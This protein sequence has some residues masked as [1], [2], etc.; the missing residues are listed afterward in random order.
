[1]LSLFYYLFLTSI[2][3][4]LFLLSLL[5]LF[6]T[7]FQ[8]IT[9]SN[10]LTINIFAGGLLMTLISIL[11]NSV[12]IFIWFTNIIANGI[13]FIVHLLLMLIV[14]LLF[15]GFYLFEL[16]VLFIQLVIFTILYGVYS[17]Y[18]D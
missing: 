13:V 16:G 5:E 2:E 7:L 14:V 17:N 6:S 11:L 15:I 3:F 1:M 12:I 9:L 10:R 8:S 4:F 18:Y